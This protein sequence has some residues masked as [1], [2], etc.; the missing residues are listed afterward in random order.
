MGKT[1]AQT[2]LTLGP[3]SPFGPGGPFFPGLP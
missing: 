2:L 1:E 3:A